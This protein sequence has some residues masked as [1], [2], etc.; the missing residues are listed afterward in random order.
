MQCD[1]SEM[2]LLWAFGHSDKKLDFLLTDDFSPEIEGIPNS[3]P[4][5]VVPREINLDMESPFD[6]NLEELFEL[7]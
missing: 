7:I 4:N 3:V 5:A 1:F 6:D 2:V